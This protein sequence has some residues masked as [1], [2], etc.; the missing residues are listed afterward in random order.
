MLLPRAPHQLH[1]V[2]LTVSPLHVDNDRKCHGWQYIARA[3][4][5]T[6]GAGA[7]YTIGHY[8][9]AVNSQDPESPLSGCK[10]STFLQTKSLY[11]S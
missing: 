7:L 5:S 3:E 10:F 11:R 9:D 6:A 8:E 4:S 2:L 1:S